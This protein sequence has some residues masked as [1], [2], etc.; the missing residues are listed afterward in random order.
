MWR[1]CGSCGRS[2]SI[3]RASPL[4]LHQERGHLGGGGGLMREPTSHSVLEVLKSCRE[5]WL[6]PP[7]RQSLHGC[8]DGPTGES[9]FAGGVAALRQWWQQKASNFVVVVA[10]LRVRGRSSSGGG[11]GESTSGSFE[12]VKMAALHPKRAP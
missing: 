7:Q 12:D 4:K 2:E 9:Y 11:R 8:Q 6:Q 10:V 3:L 5:N 1:K